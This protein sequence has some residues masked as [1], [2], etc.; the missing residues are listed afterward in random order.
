MHVRLQALTTIGIFA[1]VA[2]LGVEARQA[3]VPLAPTLVPATVAGN[4][5]TLNWIAN[6]GG[7]A[8][9]AYRIVAGSAPGLADI[10]ILDVPPTP[11][12]LTVGAPSGT[13]FVRIAALNAAG[14]SVVSNEITV[15]VG[16]VSPCVV[17]GIP[18]GLTA[19]P[20]AG[21][22]TL[23]WTP[24]STGAGPTN[25][26][27]VAGT[28]SGAINLGTFPVG[29]TTSVNAPAP[30]GQYFV[31]VVA[32]NGCGTSAPSNEVFFV[33]GGAAVSVP[34]GR[35]VGTVSNFSVAGVAPIT[36]FN[37]QLNQAV[38]S[39]STF[40]TLSASWTDNRGCA[41]SSGIV[42]AT[43]TTGPLISLESFA[44]NDGD[45]GLR[46]TNANGNVYSGAC[47]LGG[48]NCTFTMTR[49]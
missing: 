30:N 7:S 41:K 8:A 31:R 6:P 10:A 3:G 9:T 29:L 14:S 35:Y 22:V 18:S 33:I 20:F 26:T 46:V 34:A 13:Y 39:T 45:F 32:T 24:P 40:Q 15:L 17:P 21:G 25:Y 16:A 27:L 5:V 42:A 2:V 38:P 1:V 23:S 4:V 49:Q 44:C 19:A 28:A 11:T 12:T 37:L 36:S 43:T 48:P 47:N